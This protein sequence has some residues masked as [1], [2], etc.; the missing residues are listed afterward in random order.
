MKTIPHSVKVKKG[1]VY[2]VVWS[3]LIGENSD[4]LAE[5]RRDLKQ[6]IIKNGQSER[7]NW[8]CFIHEVLHLIE[9]EFKIPLSHP[10]VYKLEKAII[11]ILINN[12]WLD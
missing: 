6:I 2:E 1:L 7:A 5:C 8:E 9:F 4:T 11:K 3:D 10:L 12:G